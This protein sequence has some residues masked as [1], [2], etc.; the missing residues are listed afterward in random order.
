[1]QTSPKKRSYERPTLAEKGR[2]EQVVAV[3]SAPIQS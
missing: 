1:M 2:L 3:A